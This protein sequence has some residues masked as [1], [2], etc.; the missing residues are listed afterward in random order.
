VQNL[1]T[2]D[3]AERVLTGEETAVVAFLHS[4]SV[5]GV[6]HTFS[7]QHNQ[8]IRRLL[9]SNCNQTGHV[10]HPAKTKRQASFVSLTDAAC[11]NW[12]IRFNPK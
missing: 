9:A 5:R 2:A 11:L 6:P 4:L 3:E 8:V 1:T 10:T 7:T 12:Y